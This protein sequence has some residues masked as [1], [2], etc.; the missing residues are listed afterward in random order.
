MPIRGSGAPVSRSG[1]ASDEGSVRRLSR[2]GE[3]ERRDLR[4]VDPVRLAA[5]GILLQM[6][7]ARR[8]IDRPLRVAASSFAERDRRFLWSLVQETVRWRARLDAVISPLLHRP[9]ERLDPSVRIILRLAAVQFCVLDSIP[10]HAVVNESVRM[11]QRMAPQGADRLVNAVCHRLTEDGRARWAQIDE[12]GRSI[13]V[14][15]F[16]TAIPDG[17]WS[18]GSRDGESSRPW[19]SSVGTTRAQTSGSARVRMG[20]SRR[21][22]RAGFRT[23][24]GWNRSTVLSRIPAFLLGHFTVQDP[25]ETLDRA[26]S[27]PSR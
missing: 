10:P 24:T 7:L 8:S 14:T 17:S 12:A 16:P 13:A 26:A 22:R 25:S 4:S 2:R 20:P 3:S 27:T 19:R 9:I 15:G 1:N 5:F 11:A 18:D 6:E 23:R 21:A